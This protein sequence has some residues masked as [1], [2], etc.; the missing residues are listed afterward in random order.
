MVVVSHGGL[1]LVM[2]GIPKAQTTCLT[3]SGPVLCPG[4]MHG[5]GG[6]L[7]GL[8]IEYAWIIQFFVTIILY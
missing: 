1:W 4:D 8:K 3:S 6:L 7:I 2:W 5:C